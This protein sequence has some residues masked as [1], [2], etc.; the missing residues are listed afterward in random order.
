MPS[1]KLVE[2]DEPVVV[3][4]T[5]TLPQR[6]SRLPRKLRFPILLA[7]NFWVNGA[8]WSVAENFIPPELGS[9][10]KIEDDSVRLF[11]HLAYRIGFLYFTWRAN[12]DCGYLPW[13]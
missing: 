7:L 6:T 3:T 5:A 2:R 9:V 8:L 13:S 11:A 10:T 4:N 12:Y 1:S